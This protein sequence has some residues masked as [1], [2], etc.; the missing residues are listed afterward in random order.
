MAMTVIGFIGA[1]P[2]VRLK[3]FYGFSVRTANLA[4]QQAKRIRIGPKRRL[5]VCFSRPLL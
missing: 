1:T 2:A 3:S 5:P 4:L